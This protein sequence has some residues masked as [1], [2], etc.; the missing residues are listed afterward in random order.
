MARTTLRFRLR[1]MPVVG[2][3]LA[4]ARRRTQRKGFPGSARYWEDVYATGGTSGP[5]S[6][7]P[8]AEFKA[9]FIND[10]LARYEVRS[11]IEFGCGDGHQLGLINYAN[12]VGIDVSETAIAR[13]RSRYA[14][15]T[16]KQFFTSSE[17]ATQRVARP[18]AALSLDVIFH[19]VERD[20]YAT[21]LNELFAAAERFVLLF[22]SDTSDWPLQSSTAE[23]FHRPV[24]R[25]VATHFPN[26]RLIEEHKNPRRYRGDST[27]GSYANFL[28]Y[29][30]Q[31]APA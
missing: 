6:Y 2:D 15:D 22:T 20:V 4:A 1:E 16:S 11:V 19:L 10:F 3:A 13:C 5:G 24:K 21:Y 31:E 14:D 23:V 27:T 30:R 28:L 17:F 8:H 9:Q 25:D 18:E 12:Y 29:A 7:G 26:W